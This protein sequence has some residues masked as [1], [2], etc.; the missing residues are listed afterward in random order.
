[1]TTEFKGIRIARTPP[2]FSHPT[3]R[4]VLVVDDDLATVETMASFIKACGHEVQFAI[5]ARAALA[6][7]KKFHPDVVLLNFNLP[8]V[9]ATQFADELKLA[10][11]EAKTRVVAISADHDMKARALQAGCAEFHVK[12]VS[13]DLLERLLRGT[14]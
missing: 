14:V 4:R 3:A 2:S 13:L 5:N 6:A 12:P 9:C 1:M 7:A 11:G 8:G 10:R